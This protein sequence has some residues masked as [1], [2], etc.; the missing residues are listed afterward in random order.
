MKSSLLVSFIL[1]VSVV[2]Q[3]KDKQQQQ[4]TVAANAEAVK[5]VAVTQLLKDGWRIDHDSQFQV[6]F[7]RNRSA[8]IG[9]LAALGSP[10]CGSGPHAYLTMNFAE[11]GGQTFVSANQQFSRVGPDCKEQRW[12]VKGT[13]EAE[14]QDTMIASIKA[15]AESS[16]IAAPMV[17]VTAPTPAEG[18]QLKAVSEVES[19]PTAGES[20][21]DAAKRIKQ[22]EACLGFAKDNPSIICK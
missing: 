15:A 3:A 10:N 14:K 22:H 2:S 17:P 20:V 16:P 21:G 9:F 4:V 13:A 19:Q 5:G 6:V 1:L 18:A 12:D 8:A 7:V 11:T